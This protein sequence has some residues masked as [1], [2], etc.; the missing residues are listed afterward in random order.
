MALI[1]SPLIGAYSVTSPYI[2]LSSLSETGIQD[3]PELR[4]APLLLVMGMISIHVFILWSINIGLL[5]LTDSV[6]ER[7]QPV[8]RIFAS[9][10]IVLI[11]V[12]MAISAGGPLQRHD[13][14]LMRYYPIIGSITNNT[15][16]LL[17]LYLV[18]RNQ[19]KAQLQIKNAAL[20]MSELNKKLELLLQQVQPHFLFN[21]LATLKMLIVK[22]REKASQ[23]TSRLSGFL[24]D[25]LTSDTSM[26]ATVKEEIDRLENYIALQKMRFGDAFEYKSSISADFYEKKLPGFSLQALAENALKHNNFSEDEPLLLDYEEKD[27]LLICSNSFTPT[28]EKTHNTGLGLS[29]LKER[30]T[31]LGGKPPTIHKNLKDKRFSVILTPL[32]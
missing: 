18:V 27:G 5:K 3:L 10:A 30:F 4:T 25:S 11:L 26:L 31:L 13:F 28:H 23:Y 21:A 16:V 6:N 29:N 12:S 22:D 7:I 24:R 9:Y 1:S 19:E 14:G 32:S 17:L 8:V 2:F 20:K 15:F